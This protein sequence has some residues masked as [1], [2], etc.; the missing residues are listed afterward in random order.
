MTTPSIKW[1]AVGNSGREYRV[2]TPIGPFDLWQFGPNGAWFVADADTDET[3]WTGFSM[4]RGLD[5]IRE[6][7]SEVYA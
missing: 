2:D 3:V 7:A 4:E 1:T 6:V 5:A